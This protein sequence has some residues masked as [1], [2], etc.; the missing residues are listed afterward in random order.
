MYQSNKTPLS[1]G[2]L[3]TAELIDVIARTTVI[4]VLSLSFVLSFFVSVEPVRQPNIAAG[5]V[6]E[7]KEIAKPEVSTYSSEQY[8]KMAPELYG[9]NYVRRMR[10]EAEAAQQTVR[11]QQQAKAETAK[12]RAAASRA[13][14]F[15][16][17]EIQGISRFNSTTTYQ[18]KNGGQVLFL[19][20][21]GTT[22]SGTNPFDGFIVTG[23]N[24][25]IRIT[26]VAD[27]SESTTLSYDMQDELN[28]YKKEIK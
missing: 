8:K 20:F 19:T 26:S 5:G 24:N 11:M 2:K 23:E 12:T 22:L 21:K 16:N 1:E 14:Q 18:V 4:I 6:I 3:Y 9:L 25:A 17:I 10:A 13:V 15:P 27:S 7:V 28:K